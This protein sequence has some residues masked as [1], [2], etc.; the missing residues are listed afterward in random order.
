MSAL[1][2][3]NIS[4]VIPCRNEED[5][6]HICLKSVKAFLIPKNCKYEILVIDGKS[7]DKKS[8]KLQQSKRFPIG[9]PNLH[10]FCG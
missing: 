5:H 10:P 1:R 9:G 6:I 8:R 3:T 7:G 4:I 2:K